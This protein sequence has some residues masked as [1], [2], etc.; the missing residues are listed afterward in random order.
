MAD[1]IDA[2]QP[3]LQQARGRLA[4]AKAQEGQARLSWNGDRQRADLQQALVASQR[5]VRE[6]QGWFDQLQRSVS[7]LPGALE[8]ARRAL[9]TEE[10]TYAGLMESHRKAAVQ[11]IRRVQQARAQ[12]ER[13]EA[14]WRAIAGDVDV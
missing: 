6:A 8:E 14:D 1:A 10:T 3:L 9:L 11:Q 4:Q 12:V 2:S 7:A 5:E 13:L